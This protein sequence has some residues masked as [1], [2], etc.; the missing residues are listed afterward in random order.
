MM[1]AECQVR[2]HSLRTRCP[3]KRKGPTRSHRRLQRTLVDDE[4]SMDILAKLTMYVQ[5]LLM[6]AT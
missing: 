6:M 5:E 1:T 2:R 4:E 3:G